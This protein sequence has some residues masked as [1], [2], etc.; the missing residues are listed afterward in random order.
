MVHV[1]GPLSPHVRRLPVK[2][3]RGR[4][5]IWVLWPPP[6]RML[7]DSRMRQSMTRVVMRRSNFCRVGGLK[8]FIQLQRKESRDMYFNQCICPKKQSWHSQPCRSR[9]ATEL[10]NQRRATGPHSLISCS[11]SPSLAIA[12]A[13]KT[14]GYFNPKPLLTLG[15]TVVK[16]YQ[17]KDMLKNKRFQMQQGSS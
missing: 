7:A 9:K 11:A 13:H 4:P 15:S 3:M 8:H 5:E 10:K 14:T 6:G 1:R 12:T 2:S 16:K 17:K